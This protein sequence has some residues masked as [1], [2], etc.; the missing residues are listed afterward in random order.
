MFVLNTQIFARMP[1]P[2]HDYSSLDDER[3]NAEEL[4]V[5]YLAIDGPVVQSEYLPYN[6]PTLTDFGL[7]KVCYVVCLSGSAVVCLSRSAMLC[8]CQGL[9]CCVS[10]KICYVV[11]LSRSAMLCLSRSAIVCLSRSAMLCLSRSAILCVCQGLLC[12]VSVKVCC[13]VCLSKSVVLCLL[14]SCLSVF[15]VCHFVVRSVVMARFM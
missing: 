5:N 8:V 3:K 7:D 10:V 6:K 9:L 2:S 4:C 11:C 1:P 13:V 15:C 14:S 12:C